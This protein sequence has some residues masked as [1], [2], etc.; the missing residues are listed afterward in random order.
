MDS[1]LFLSW[2]KSVKPYTLNVNETR[3]QV[4]NFTLCCFLSSSFSSFEEE[5]MMRCASSSFSTTA[6]SSEKSRFVFNIIHGN[7]RTRRRKRKEF[8][9]RRNSQKWCSSSNNNNNNKRTTTRMMGTTMENSSSNNDTIVA[10]AT[11]IVPQL[12]GVSIVRISGENAREIANE[13]FK[14]TGK[15]KRRSFETHVVLHGTIVNNNDGEVIDEVLLLPMLKPRSYTAEDVVEIHT[16]GGSVCAARVLDACLRT[17]ACR[18]ARNGEFT[19]RAFLNGRLDLSQA[20][21][22]HSLIRAETDEAAVQALKTLRG[23]LSNDVKEAR[24]RMIDVLAE[25]EAR[26]D[27]DDEM[28]PLDVDK[29]AKEV[30]EA[31]E[32]ALSALKTS[33]KNA[34][35]S[36]GCTLAIVGRPN[37]GKSRLL[38]R[39]TKSERSIVTDV[40]GTTRDVVEA[41]VNVSGV[42]VTL[43]DTAGIRG[44][45]SRNSNSSNSN[46]SSGSDDSNKEE[47]TEIIDKVEAVGIERSKIAARGADLCAFVLDASRG[48]ERADETVW[49]EALDVAK[50]VIFVAN[51]MDDITENAS[52]IEEMKS[53][54]SGKMKPFLTNRLRVPEYVLDKCTLNNVVFLSAK[55]GFG[56]EDLESK[57]SNAFESGLS[58]VE[59][60]AY[61]VSSRQSE[62][63]KHA[64][65]AMERV[66]ESALNDLPVDFWTIDLR[67]AAVALGEVTG[68][69]VSED[70]LGAIFERFCIGK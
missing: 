36:V 69:D 5:R 54:P 49:R 40:E 13:I 59:G 60:D 3:K 9:W 52:L 48:W 21:A 7:E 11:P 27:F 37:A 56:I 65:E 12:G 32:V 15:R 20:E 8:F 50:N 47:E 53:D 43:L 6:Q 42:K 68:E 45:S 64:V 22:V 66:Q 16:H 55:E 39:W 35:L 51:K 17:N 14:P 2:S 41:T 26:L 38:N 1:R 29:I 34:S 70:I 44:G 31:K 46:G 63:L 61:F 18:L 23:G 10:I 28:V 24:G 25:L 58:S 67:E 33:Q 62:A 4:E 30:D 57:V 19:M